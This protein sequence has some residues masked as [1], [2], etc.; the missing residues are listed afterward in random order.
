MILR[1]AM[2]V[3]TSPVMSLIT[4]GPKL[5]TR[6]MQRAYLSNSHRQLNGSLTAGRAWTNA[7]SLFSFPWTAG[8]QQMC[9]LHVCGAMFAA[10]CP[11][12]IDDIQGR[13]VTDN[14]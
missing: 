8:A 2:L 7:R 3:E 13:T 6:L 9:P 12:C 4:S 11:S 10:P 1:I 14:P 5:K